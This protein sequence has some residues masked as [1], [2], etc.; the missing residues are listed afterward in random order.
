MVDTPTISLGRAGEPRRPSVGVGA[1]RPTL[2]PYARP[3][4]R[5]APPGTE[6]PIEA[7]EE[8]AGAGAA[9]TIPLA[10]TSTT[11]AKVVMGR[12]TLFV[13]PPVAYE[14]ARVLSARVDEP[15]LL[16]TH[17]IPPIRV[18]DGVVAHEAGVTDAVGPP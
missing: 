5:P 3:E 6:N 8:V 2:G 14:D 15:L 11:A 16:V 10:V 17:P 12:H 4:A 13:R 18:A 9:P 7:E 1:L